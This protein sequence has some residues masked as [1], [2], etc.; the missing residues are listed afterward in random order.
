MQDIGKIAAQVR[1]A[2]G[3]LGWSQAYLAQ[4]TNVRRAI[5]AELESG[6]CEPESSTLS[7]L[8]KEL[9]AAGIVF[10]DKGIEL[11]SWPLEPY[12]PAGCVTVKKRMRRRYISRAANNG[13]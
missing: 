12:V 5:I 11:R 1:G 10:T 9:C 7:V 2:R 13:K 3:L 6:A 8:M 4:G